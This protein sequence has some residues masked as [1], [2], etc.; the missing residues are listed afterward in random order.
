[1]AS[2]TQELA[3]GLRRRDPALLDRVIEQYHYRLL[4]YLL[5]LTGNREN[6]EDIFQETWIRVLERGHQYDGKRRFET[7]LFT[8]ARNLVIDRSRGK[9]LRNTVSLDQPP[10]GQGET[11]PARA[12]AARDRSPFEEFVSHEESGRIVK[13]L[14]A[15]PSVY[16]EA[17]ALRFQEEMPLEEIAAITSAPLSTVKSRIYRGIEALRQFLEEQP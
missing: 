15:L 17:L 1:M 12:Q 7:W 2:E 3:R 6:A 5:Y 4:R 11:I 14:D 10:A 9:A 8:I 13:A 16:R